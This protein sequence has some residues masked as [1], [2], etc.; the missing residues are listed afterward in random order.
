MTISDDY[1][2]SVG[3]AAKVI[4][5]HK[6]VNHVMAANEIIG[7]CLSGKG[8]LVGKFVLETTDENGQLLSKPASD[9][10][11]AI[12]TEIS[13]NTRNPIVIWHEKDNE[14]KFVLEN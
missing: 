5:N 14:R 6:A 1:K 9:L 4:S 11:A 8:V 13:W 7:G 10:A 12:M 2:D 3:Y